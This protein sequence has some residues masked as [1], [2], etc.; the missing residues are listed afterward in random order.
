M[1]LHYALYRLNQ[2]IALFLK[3]ISLSAL[4]GGS[5]AR[6]SVM[7]PPTVLKRRSGG[8]EAGGPR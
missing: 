8:T 2:A 4:S 1:Q 5:R 3:K 6:C 7:T